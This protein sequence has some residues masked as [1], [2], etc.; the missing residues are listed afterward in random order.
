M[1][2]NIET[3][4]CPR[5]G[6]ANREGKGKCQVCY[7]EFGRNDQLEEQALYSLPLV[8]D[9]NGEWAGRLI[10]TN[11]RFIH[12]GFK[13]YQATSSIT[14]IPLSQLFLADVIK[15][16]KRNKFFADRIIGLKN[17]TY[18]GKLFS[19]SDAELNKPLR[20]L[21]PELRSLSL[22]EEV[23]GGSP[24]LAKHVNVVYYSDVKVVKL[25]DVPTP[26]GWWG[27]RTGELIGLELHKG[28]GH[29]SLINGYIIPFNLSTEEVASMLRRTP[30]AYCE[31]KFDKNKVL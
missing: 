27:S 22:N 19:V 18:K 4:V 21:M 25:Y 31:F 3:T 11:D 17:G 29:F 5:C 14:S 8:L 2:K 10:I 26:K 20:E 12:W 24:A 28:E 23:R 9:L 30:L 13:S 16:F 6:Y 15:V 1:S 7:Y